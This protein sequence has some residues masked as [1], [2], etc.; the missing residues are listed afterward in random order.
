MRN[1]ITEMR[2]SEILTAHRDE[3]YDA[4]GRASVEYILIPVGLSRH[5]YFD[6]KDSTKIPKRITI[7]KVAIAFKL[8]EAEITELFR[9]HGYYFPFTPGD[10]IILNHIREGFCTDLNAELEEIG[11]PPIYDLTTDK[12]PS[13][14][15]VNV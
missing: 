5:S 9:L 7:K 14:L 2:I 4:D 6:V 12:D 3:L 13:K 11:E 1:F 10:H 8:N 15:S